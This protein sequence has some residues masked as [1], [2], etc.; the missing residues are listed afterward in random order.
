MQGAKD[1]TEP[2]PLRGAGDGNRAWATS[3]LD[4]EGTAMVAASAACGAGNI[5]G[6]RCAEEDAPRNLRGPSL[7]CV[8][9]GGHDGRHCGRQSRD[10]SSS[11]GFVVM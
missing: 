6:S 5:T 2:R 1:P 4:D 11:V 8:D 9:D 7:A 10:H 3:R